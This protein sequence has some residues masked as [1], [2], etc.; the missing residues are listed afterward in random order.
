MVHN[1]LVTTA[2]GADT[3]I[4]DF[5]SKCLKR[6]SFYVMFQQRIIDERNKYFNMKSQIFEYFLYI[7]THTPTVWQLEHT[8]A[9]F[10]GNR[11]T[12]V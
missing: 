11:N 7:L 6:R 2:A 1:Y 12:E 8:S 5:T 4:K 9:V 10:Y 3:V